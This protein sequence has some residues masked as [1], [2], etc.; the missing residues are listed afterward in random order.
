MK[1]M[2]VLLFAVCCVLLAVMQGCGQAESKAPQPAETPA[3]QLSGRVVQHRLQVTLYPERGELEV[4]DELDLSAL[5]AADGTIKRLQLDLNSAFKVMHDQQALTPVATQAGISRYQFNNLE[6]H[7]LSLSYRGKLASTKDCAWLVQACALLNKDGVFLDGSSAWYPQISGT[8]QRF[9]MEVML[10]DGW[11]SLSQG[12]QTVQGWEEQ[13]PQRDIYLLAGQFHVYEAEQKAGQ[14]KAMV[15]L[16]SEDPELAE[17]YLQATARYVDE[18]SRLLGSYPYAKFATVES[19]WETGW[20]MPSFT[21]LGSRVMRLPFILH[22]SFPHEILHNWWGNGVYVDSRRGNWSEGLTAYLSDHRNKQVTGEGLNYRRDTLQKY[23]AFTAAGGDFPLS[24]FRSRHDRTTQAIGYGKSLMLFHMLHERLGDEVFFTALRQFYQTHQFE[25]AD[26][27]ALR[28][29]FEQSSGEDLQVFFQQWLDGTGAPVLG[30]VGHQLQGNE[31]GEQQ[32]A[33]QLQQ[34]QDGKPFTLDIPLRIEFQDGSQQRQTLRMGQAEQDYALTFSN[35]LS[36]ISIDPAFD[37]FRIPDA[38]EVPPALNVLF[39]RQPKTFVLS[40]KV[41]DGMEL[42]WDD[43]VD[44][45]SYGQDMKVQYDDEALPDAGVVVLLGGDNAMLSGLLDRAQQPFKLTETAYTL[46]S[47]NYTCGLH[48]LALTLRAGEQQIILLD[49][50]TEQGLNSLARKLPHYGKYSY[51]L[52]N[53]ASGDNVA[54]GQWEVKDSPLSI[55]FE[56]K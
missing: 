55:H 5:T 29:V 43:F 6:Q 44:T 28:E 53:S 42:V 26:F 48:S 33:L 49:A 56:E 19:F 12:A 52:F 13:Q 17:R 9:S 23:A 11:I 10:P 30:I 31:Q 1:P 16:Q 14:P 50:S 20:G 36:R 35:K 21:L 40:R 22:S 41:P 8:S 7:K 46:N 24:E 54:K 39:N 25:Y 34:T 47:V 37:L 38:R 18:Y 27:D 32:L 51:V 45:F 2:S 4:S 3:E 15:Y